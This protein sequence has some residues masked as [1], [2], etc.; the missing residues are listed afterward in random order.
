MLPAA[1]AHCASVGAPAIL[2]N[3]PPFFIID[4]ARTAVSALRAEPDADAAREEVLRLIERA[5]R[6]PI[7]ASTSKAF[8]NPSRERWDV[9]RMESIFHFPHGFPSPIF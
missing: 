2:T 9:F 1:A 6:Q 7:A 3:T 5:T 8:K 4:N